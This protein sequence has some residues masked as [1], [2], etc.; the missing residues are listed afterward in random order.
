MAVK[1][2]DQFTFP[3]MDTLLAL[4]PSASIKQ[5]H[6]DVNEDMIGVPQQCRCTKKTESSYSI[7]PSSNKIVAIC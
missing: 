2:S 3:H 6:G 5:I 7:V 1:K 4:L